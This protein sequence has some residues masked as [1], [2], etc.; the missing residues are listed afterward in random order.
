MKLQN[1]TSQVSEIF[2]RRIIKALGLHACQVLYFSLLVEMIS[3]LIGLAINCDVGLKNPSYKIK[4]LSEI[5]F[6]GKT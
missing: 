5:K 3:A 6:L 4:K 1:F 2:E